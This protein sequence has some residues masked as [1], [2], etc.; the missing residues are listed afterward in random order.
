MG[1]KY[2]IKCKKTKPASEFHR[3]TKSRDGLQAYCKECNI[4]NAMGHFDANKIARR[5]ARARRK[6]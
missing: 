4:A 1:E 3:L 2:C 5:N 6:A